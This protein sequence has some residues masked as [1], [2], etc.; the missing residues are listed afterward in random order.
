MW[1]FEIVV[2]SV[3][4]HMCIIPALKRLRQE[5]PEFHTIWGDS[6]SENIGQKK[7]EEEEET[8]RS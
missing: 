5:N 3:V 8:A 2:K 1:K 4:M 7:K 6:F